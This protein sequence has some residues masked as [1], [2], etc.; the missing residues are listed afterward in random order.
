VDQPL[1]YEQL[2]RRY[3]GRVRRC[4]LDPQALMQAASD[5][6]VVMACD[7]TGNF[8]FPAL[9]PAID[10][11]F[12]LGKLLEMLAHQQT[13]LSAV[14]AGLPPFHIATGMVVGAW[15]TKGRIMRCL[16]Q[17]FAKLR[18]E[19][20]DGIK[21]H[22]GDGEWVLI[23][24]DSDTATFHLVAEARSL[25]A[26]QELIADYGGI[27]HRYTQKPYPDGAPPVLLKLG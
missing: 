23:R 14:I 17:Q 27:V 19:T 20:I 13:Q 2:A 25:Q 11:L 18:Y 1:V 21:V 12:A 10:G 7:G 24:P 6:K 5:D 22:L 16:I 3:G 8:V 26:A 9:H 4:P 15:E